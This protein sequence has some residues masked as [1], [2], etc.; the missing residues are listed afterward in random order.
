MHLEE[1]WNNA[2]AGN[3][4]RGTG[5]GGGGT[6]GVGPCE[7]AR[8]YNR[9]ETV[10]QGLAC[11]RVA[12]DDLSKATPLLRWDELVHYVIRVES[13]DAKLVKITTKEGFAA[14][15]PSRQAYSAVHDVNP[16]CWPK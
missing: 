11:G 5:N 12:E 4:E 1:E 16:R 13:L 15:N 6:R 14:G 3:G 9:V 8:S 10:L 7:E 2:N